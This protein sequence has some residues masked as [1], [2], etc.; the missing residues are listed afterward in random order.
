[1]HRN[2][3]FTLVELLV[4]IAIIGI[5]AS[6]L[7]PS[8]LKARSKSIQAVCKSQLKQVGIAWQHYFGDN[9]ERFVPEQNGWSA[10][11]Y[12]NNGT[13]VL[14]QWL[15]YQVY[16]DLYTQETQVYICPEKTR[17]SNHQSDADLFQHDYSMPGFSNITYP[18]IED[19]TETALGVDAGWMGIP[20][21]AQRRLEARHLAACNILWVDGH[22]TSKSASAIGENPDW[23]TRYSRYNKWTRTYQ[24]T[25]LGEWSSG[26]PI[27]IPG[28]N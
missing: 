21:W 1:M 15:S 27:S 14:T 20:Y 24:E 6:I 17:N 26:G 9:N 4:V 11:D 18:E 5:L 2:K 12:Y 25:T 19:P 8:L 10:S 3:F 7:M 28:V 22:V 13:H 16:L 23:F